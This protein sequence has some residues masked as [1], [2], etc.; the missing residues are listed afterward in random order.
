MTELT[1]L[2]F[3]GQKKRLVIFNLGALKIVITL[4]TLSF[5]LHYAISS[6]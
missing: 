5:I 4:K 3:A 2:K 6:L 1:S